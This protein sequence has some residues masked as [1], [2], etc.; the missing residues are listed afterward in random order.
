MANLRTQIIKLAFEQPH[1]REHLLPVLR[2]EAMEFPT[3]EALEDYLKDHPGADRA[4]HH[5]KRQDGLEGSKS[6][7]AE[8]E[9]IKSMNR[10]FDSI[11][12]E[13][14]D[15]A[16]GLKAL[17]DKTFHKKEVTKD[18]VRKAQTELRKKILYYRNRDLKQA[19]R[20]EKLDEQLTAFLR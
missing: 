3:K 18:D 8:G 19:E 15:S 6:T 17:G 13:I 1:L 12:P 10:I 4:N 20:M 16:P 11:N 2:K 5:V 14:V 7:S 9:I